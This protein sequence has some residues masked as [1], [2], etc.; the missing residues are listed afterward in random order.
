[1]L[2]KFIAT[3]FSAIIMLTIFV[4]LIGGTAWAYRKL[5]NDPV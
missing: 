3:N 5:F 4:L 1:M 2:S